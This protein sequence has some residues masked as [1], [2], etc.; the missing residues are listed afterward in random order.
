MSL[1]TRTGR[2]LSVSYSAM[3]LGLM[4]VFVI[5]GCGMKGPPQPP[6]NEGNTIASPY[7]LKISGEK[8]LVTLSWKHETTQNAQVKPEGFEVF[9]A[10][11]TPDDCEGCPVAFHSIGSVTAPDHAITVPVKSGIRY[12]FR[13]QATDDGALKSEYSNTALFESK[14]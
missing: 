1:D 12:Y 8:D 3:L 2:I 10:E 4:A 5:A 9:M 6:I 14:P 7:D 11:K 13:V